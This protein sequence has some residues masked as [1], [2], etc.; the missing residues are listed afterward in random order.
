VGAARRAHD[1]EAALTLGRAVAGLNA[2]AKGRRLGVFDEPEREAEER[3]R[4]R[5]ARR[6]ERLVPLLGRSVP[7]VDTARGLRAAE[8]GRPVSPASVERYLRGKF[9]EAL[10]DARAAMEA[11]AAAYEPAQLEEVAFALYE[12]FRPRIPPGVRGWG[13]KGVLDLDLVRSLADE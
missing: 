1:R 3:P 5:G 13:A 12:R 4:A 11:L 7:A 9:G 6:R 8:G 10:P 2:Q